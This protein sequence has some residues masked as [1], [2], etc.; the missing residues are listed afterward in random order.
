MCT[1]MTALIKR[2]KVQVVIVCTLHTTVRTLEEQLQY[3]PTKSKKV[4]DLKLILKKAF[5]VFSGH[6][7]LKPHTKSYTM[8][9]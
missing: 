4:C 7:N 8:H 1:M 2:V 3:V 6:R 9:L 5:R